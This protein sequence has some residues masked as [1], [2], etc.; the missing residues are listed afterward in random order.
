MGIG[1]VLDKYNSG[2]ISHLRSACEFTFL[3]LFGLS[4]WLLFTVA[5]QDALKEEM[6]FVTSLGLLLV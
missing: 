6:C 3:L 2:I 5:M 1:W 4:S